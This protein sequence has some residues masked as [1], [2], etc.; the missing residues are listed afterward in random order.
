MPWRAITPMSLRFEFV[1][2][3]SEA[4]LAFSELCRR[5]GI[6]RKTGYKWLARYKEAGAEALRDPPRRPLASPRQVQ[7]A[8]AESVIA[9]RRQ[10]PAWGGR[11][12]RRRLQ[13]LGA[14][15]V[16]SASTCT[17]ILRR[18]DLLNDK[19]PR[20]PMQR[21][22]RAMPNELWQMDHKG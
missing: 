9:L 4:S 15:Q 10:N 6:S 3:A 21:F 7:P 5:Y 18:A 1:I 11:K 19:T 13:D 2:L 20:G 8:M 17:E 14:T 16:P 12:L 22:E